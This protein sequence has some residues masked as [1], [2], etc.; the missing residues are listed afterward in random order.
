VKYDV[1]VQRHAR[2]DIWETHAWIAERAPSA[3]DKWL[4]RLQAKISTLEERPDRCPVIAKRPRLSFDVRE[5]LYGRKPYVFR[6]I[7]VIDGSRVRVLRVRR[8]QRRQLTSEE[9]DRAI[10]HDELSGEE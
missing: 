10:Q 5:L 7:F 2:R 1:V 3:A 8:G 9:L 6:I 4:D